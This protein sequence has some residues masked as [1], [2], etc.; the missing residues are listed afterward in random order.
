MQRL[1]LES[2]VEGVLFGSVDVSRALFDLDQV[3][4]TSNEEELVC[5]VVRQQPLLVLFSK[6]L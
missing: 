5:F 4:F 3:R 6:C 2:I 1:S